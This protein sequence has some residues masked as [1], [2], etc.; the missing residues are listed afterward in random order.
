MFNSNI[1]NNL[2]TVGAYIL[3]ENTFA[4]VI[5]PDKSGEKLGIMRLGGHIEA[6]ES[7]LQ[8]LEREIL[9]E[10][11][12]KVNL[13]NSPST[14]YKTN[15]SDNYYYEINNNLNWDIK[16]LVIRGDHSSSTAVFLSY[17][18]EEPKPSS[19]VYGIIFLKENDIKEICS[20]KLHLRDFI[21]SGGKLIQQKEINYDMEMYAGV[22]LEFLYR[23]I[24][25]GNEVVSK[26]M[27]GELI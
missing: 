17:A 4:F 21:A 6:N 10:G 7:P 14:Y 3:Y 26:Y 8:A 1:L 22:H 27:K 5:G 13:I 20:R 11:S 18:K 24:E 19:E 23:L 9:E 15:W 2:K 25:D 12:I 16:P